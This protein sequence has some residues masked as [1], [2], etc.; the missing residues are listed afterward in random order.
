MSLWSHLLSILEGAAIFK[1]NNVKHYRTF[2]KHQRALRVHLLMLFFF[3]R[4]HMRCL[5]SIKDVYILNE[6]SILSRDLRGHQLLKS[7]LFQIAPFLG[8]SRM[9][10]HLQHGEFFEFA[11]FG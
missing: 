10:S 3:Y 8:C 7:G 1:A 2:L 11:P 9:S 5:S 4:D 6:H